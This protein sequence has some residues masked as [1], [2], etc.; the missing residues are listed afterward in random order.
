VIVATVPQQA[1][2][3][4]GSAMVPL[5]SM[6]PVCIA[7]LDVALQ[8]L[9]VKQAV[10]ALGI[11]DPIYFSAD[12]ASAGLAPYAGAVAHVGRHLGATPNDGVDDEVVL[13]RFLD[14]VQ[15]GWRELVLFRRFT[16]RV[17][18]SSALVTA[19]GGGIKGR[20]GGS[21]EGLDNVFLAGDWIGPT[22]QL[23]DAAIA[24]GLRAARAVMNLTPQRSV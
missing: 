10:F 6:I 1:K 23:A 22:G 15:P 19:A 2:A 18:V 14:L 11:D 9:P 20:P 4:L 24:S 3:L 8:R 13:G 21:V 16:P 5:G 17:V 7:T 12:S